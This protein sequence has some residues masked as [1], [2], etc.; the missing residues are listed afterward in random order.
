MDTPHLIVF[1][2]IGTDPKG[3]YPVE[4]GDI[5][6]E[7]TIE[8]IPTNED[9][10]ERLEI[11]RS[12]LNTAEFFLFYDGTEYITM[13]DRKGKGF[14]TFHMMYHGDYLGRILLGMTSFKQLALDHRTYGDDSDAEYES[15][16]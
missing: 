1:H 3:D 2:T 14:V 13:Y 16:F 6:D 10:E 15:F 5:S 8:C 12:I 7:F 4:F 9:A 11:F